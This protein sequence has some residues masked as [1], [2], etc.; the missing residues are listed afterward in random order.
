[1][2]E[3]PEKI[4]IA[5]DG[6]RDSELAVRRAVDLANKTESELHVVYVMLLSHWMVPDN[7]SDAQFR[8]L[9]EEA[10]GLLA[11][12]A[13]MIRAAG[14]NLVQAHLRSGRRRTKRS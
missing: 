14:G 4:L 2:A 8:R 9:K 11:G 6:S 3:F 5:T 1:M 7:L 13:E 10:E 12:Q